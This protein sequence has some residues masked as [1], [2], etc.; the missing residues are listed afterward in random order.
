MGQPV[1]ALVPKYQA[2][3]PFAQ[4]NVAA[5]VKDS[6]LTVVPGAYLLTGLPNSGWHSCLITA[7]TTARDLASHGHQVEEREVNL[8]V[9]NDTEINHRFVVVN[10]DTIVDVTPFGAI[11]GAYPFTKVEPESFLG[12]VIEQHR[13]KKAEQKTL[14]TRRALLLADDAGDSLIAGY[15]TLIIGSRFLAPRF[16]GLTHMGFTVFGNDG[17]AIYYSSQLLCRTDKAA[18]PLNCPGK[19]GFEIQISMRQL[20][21]LRAQILGRQAT[22]VDFTNWVLTNAKYLNC[23]SPI[24]Q[25]DPRL[26]FARDNLLSMLMESWPLVAQLLRRFP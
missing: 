4:Y 21:E 2:Q 9:N 19:M 8:P 12:Q 26:P 17:L 15:R 22:F 5:A 16:L 3:F 25:V 7:D 20:R 24:N 13:D 18:I 10:G 11:L 1:G 14:T 23:L 6:T